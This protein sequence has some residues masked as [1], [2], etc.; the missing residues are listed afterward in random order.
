MPQTS[1]E[2]P[3]PLAASSAGILSTP[4]WPVSHQK[5]TQKAPYDENAVA[6][7]VLPLANSHM[8]AANWPPPPYARASP[9][10]TGSTLAGTQPA[11]TALRTNV[12][13]ANA[14]SPRGAGSAM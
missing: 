14:A 7:K 11:L 3:M 1:R 12:V 13:S 9:K 6:P 5:D 10:T 2:R 8:P 4:E